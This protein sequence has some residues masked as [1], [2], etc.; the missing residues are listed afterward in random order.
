MASD[1]L[2]TKAPATHCPP[3]PFTSLLYVGLIGGAASGKS[4]VAKLLADRGG[5]W[6]D[7]DRLAH[8]VLEQAEV[9]QIVASRFSTDIL[10][11]HGRIDRHQLAQ[12]VFGEGEPA[13]T[14]RLWLQ[15]LLHPRV[16]QLVQQRIDAAELASAVIVID[17]PMLIEAG[18]AG[19]CDRIV[20]IDTPIAQRREAAAARGWSAGELARRERSQLPLEEKLRWATD[21]LVNDG[22]LAELTAKVDTLWQQFTA[23][24][25][26]P[27][28]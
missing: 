15:H 22:N 17:A 26:D 20:F 27:P 6:I 18:W 28:I 10:D 13:T 25:Q 23:S 3:R 5:L 24:A 16:R 7:C 12:F 14:Q 11:D 21:V 19:D 8:Q 4:T 1:N 9:I 2:F